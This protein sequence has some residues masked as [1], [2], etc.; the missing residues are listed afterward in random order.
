[1]RK[2]FIAAN[3]KMHGSQQSSIAWLQEISKEARASIELAVFPPYVYLPLCQSF[4]LSYGAQ[5]CAAYPEGA[6]TGEVSATMLKALGCRYVIIGHSER[7]RF[8]M[9][10]NAVLLEKCKQ[11]VLA[12]LVPILCVGETLEAR[13]LNQT[14]SV[15]KEQLAVVAALKDNCSQFSEIL[16]AYEPVWAIGTGKAAMPSDAEV[17]HAFIRSELVRIQ[18]A[19][20]QQTRILYGGSVSPENAAAFFKMH[21]VDGVLVG[22]A[23]LRAKDFLAIADAACNS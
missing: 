9:E 12:D 19:L 3:W 1:M 4:S 16:I 18:T 17:V 11:A 7:R 5:N 13:E 14:L 15:V 10:T 20:A 22:G 8:F 23:S 21:N 2:K 6:Y